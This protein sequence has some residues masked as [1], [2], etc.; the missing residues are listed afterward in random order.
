MSH[1][2]SS[3]VRKTSRFLTST[4]QHPK[5]EALR[6]EPLAQNSTE[7]HDMTQDE[8]ED[9]RHRVSVEGPRFTAHTAPGPLSGCMV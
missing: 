1:A 5:P 3:L 8:F 2:R 7:C 6:S 4:R 9:D